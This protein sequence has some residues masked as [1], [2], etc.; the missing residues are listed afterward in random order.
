MAP[1][2]KAWYSVAEMDPG[3]GEPVFSTAEAAELDA[4]ILQSAQDL[5]QVPALGDGVCLSGTSDVYEGG[6][7]VREPGTDDSVGEE[8]AHELRQTQGVEWWAHRL[9]LR[10]VEIRD[11]AGKPHRILDIVVM[12][13]P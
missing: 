8:L 7:A 13:T 4:V 12:P 6:A 11:R 1:R 5:E 3:L 9:R 10:D 2:S